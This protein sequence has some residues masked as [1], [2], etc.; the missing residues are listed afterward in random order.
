MALCKEI[1]DIMAEAA[2]CDLS[3]IEGMEGNFSDSIFTDIQD[4][5]QL[6]M[7][8]DYTEEMVIVR[9]QDTKFGNRNIVE[10]TDLSRIMESKNLSAK[11]A[12]ESICEYYNLNPADTYVLIESPEYFIE[13][14]KTL[15][16]ACAGAKDEACKSK[17]KGKLNK[18]KK[19]VK[20]LK[21]SGIKLLTKKSEGCKS[22]GCKSKK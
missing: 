5:E 18:V 12:L 6:D 11:R 14:C 4:I 20:D 17:A 1:I 7:D 8:L 10:F 19:A 9:T 3:G 2:I 13:A 22:E 21:K 15:N 16:D